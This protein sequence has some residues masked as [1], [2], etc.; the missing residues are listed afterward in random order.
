MQ[1][2]TPAALQKHVQTAVWIICKQVTVHKVCRR[3]N[4]NV[5][6]EQKKAGRPYSY[7]FYFLP[8]TLTQKKFLHVFSSL[9]NYLQCICF[10][11]LHLKVYTGSFLHQFFPSRAFKNIFQSTVVSPEVVSF[12][13]QLQT[14]WSFSSKYLENEEESSLLAFNTYC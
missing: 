5:T 7:S 12:E 14:C 8:S 1:S 4:G 6:G 10:S 11:D 13:E 3:S 9:I 2:I